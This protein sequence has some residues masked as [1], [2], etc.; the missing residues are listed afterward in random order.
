MFISTHIYHEALTLWSYIKTIHIEDYRE[1]EE[2]GKAALVYGASQLREHINTW[3]H[4]FF[5][6][7]GF[8]RSKSDK[9]AVKKVQQT[10]KCIRKLLYFSCDIM[11]FGPMSNRAFN[12]IYHSE[13]WCFDVLR[14]CGYDDLRKG[15]ALIAESGTVFYNT[16][17]SVELL[18][19]GDCGKRIVQSFNPPNSTK[20]PGVCSGCFTSEEQEV[21]LSNLKGAFT[22]VWVTP[23][24]FREIFTGED[25]MY[26][27]AGLSL[28]GRQELQIY[29]L[30]SWCA[31][32]RQGAMRPR[33]EKGLVVDFPMAQK[34]V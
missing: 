18:R 12:R 28:E 8:M 1:P 11:D 15:Q 24:V 29:L 20:Y 2:M 19:S 4:Y 14:E 25:S 31:A 3:F 27:D 22:P 16:P 23:N 7:G 30:N 13:D 5:P 32:V 6:H 9:P 10:A 26:F 33:R 34:S 21:V 17:A